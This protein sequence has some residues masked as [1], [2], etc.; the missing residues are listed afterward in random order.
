MMIIVAMAAYVSIGQE[1][2]MRPAADATARVFWRF[3]MAPTPASTSLAA[4]HP[5]GVRALPTA[6][7]ARVITIDIATHAVVELFDCARSGAGLGACACAVIVSGNLGCKV[8]IRRSDA[9]MMSG[10]RVAAL[11]LLFAAEDGLAGAEVGCGRG[12]GA[13]VVVSNVSLCSRETRKRCLRTARNSRD[14]DAS[15]AR[16]PPFHRHGSLHAPSP[17]SV[18]PARTLP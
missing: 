10:V 6:N 13:G 7:A 2:T 9:T 11:M 18:S 12:A 16:R 5:S 14:A 15:S 1:H 17:R 4:V 8:S 3:V